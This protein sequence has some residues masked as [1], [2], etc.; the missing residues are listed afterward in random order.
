MMEVTRHSVSARLGT[1]DL[2]SVIGKL[3]AGQVLPIESDGQ[4]TLEVNGIPCFQGSLGS[5]GSRYSVQVQNRI[6]DKSQSP[7]NQKG[8]FKTLEWSES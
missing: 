8:E 4:V 1:L 5:T 7:L 3:E 6:Q 2:S